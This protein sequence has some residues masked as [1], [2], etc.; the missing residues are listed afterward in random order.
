MAVGVVQLYGA[1]GTSAAYGPLSAETRRRAAEILGLRC[2]DV[3]WHSARDRF[4]DLAA[5]PAVP[6]AAVSR[7]ALEVIDL[8]R[9]EIGEVREGAGRPAGASS[10]MPQKANPILSET[11]VG[12]S[13]MACALAAVPL[14][15]MTGRH[16]R[17]AGE[18]QMEWDS[19]P[20]LVAYVGS[21]LARCGDLVGCLRVDTE[22]MAAN[23]ET[24][25]GL[26]MAEA[27]MMHLAPLLGR[28][29]AHDAVYDLA[30]AARA[31]GIPLAEAALTFCAERGQPAEAHLDPKD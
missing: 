23:L 12:L 10:T 17:S 18:W 4:A 5:A 30:A 25:G 31:A 28:K 27:L 29:E 8:A 20:L 6:A 14:R 9:S 7:I 19:L 15:A 3:P 26:I 21:A 1:A 13:G 2:D 22:R 24:D 11:I 16:E